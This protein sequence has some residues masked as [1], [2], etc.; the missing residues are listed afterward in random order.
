MAVPLS[1]RT[2]QDNHGPTEVPTIS[3]IHPLSPIRATNFTLV[4]LSTF[5]LPYPCNFIRRKR[6]ELVTTKIELKAMAPAAI[7]GL[8]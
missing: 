6:N 2:D 4:Y 8:S 5:P 3:I 7:M 1:P